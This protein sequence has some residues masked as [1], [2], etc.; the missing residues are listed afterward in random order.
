MAMTP[1]LSEEL[2][3]A[4]RQSLGFVEGDTFILMTKEIYLSAMSECTQ[5]DVEA[6]NKGLADIEAGRTRP[7]EDFF[8]DFDSKHGI[9]S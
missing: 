4:L 5:E 2:Q 8:R 9:Q 6:T 1:K 7:V 3:E